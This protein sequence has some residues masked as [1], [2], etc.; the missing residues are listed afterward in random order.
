MGCASSTSPPSSF[1]DQFEIGALIGEGSFGRIYHVERRRPTSL[2]Q[3]EAPGYDN[4]TVAGWA[5]KQLC[6]KVINTASK[7]EASERKRASC[8]A[9][10]AAIW[11]QIGQHVNCVELFHKY[12]QN[13]T[14]YMVME[15]CEG[16]FKQEWTRVQ[17]MLEQDS[18]RMFRELTLGV[19]HLHHVGIVHRDIKIENLLLGGPFGT[20]VKL[21]DFGFATQMPADMLLVG[22]YGTAPYMSP[23]MVMDVGYDC[24]TDVW[25]LGCVIHV[26]LCASFP[27]EVGRI[28][29]RAMKKAIADDLPKL[30][31][32]WADVHD[33]K[34]SFLKHMLDRTQSSRYSAEQVLSLP[35]LS[36]KDSLTQLSLSEVRR[37]RKVAKAGVSDTW[38]RTQAM[39]AARERENPA[40]S[41]GCSKVNGSSIGHLNT[42]STSAESRS[43]RNELLS[44][45]MSL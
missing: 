20:T 13:K 19:A 33:V 31:L 18:T 25:S 2:S 42:S 26:L 6:V 43:G 38:I 41:N 11:R 27:Y 21:A 8:A 24:K 30:D 10:E 14:W 37:M 44:M 5:G 28:D 12:V 7:D 29:L 23:E 35:S 39:Q 22:A 32:N 36:H 16:S 17:H 3:R 1:H 45:T 40:I 15:K 34:L 4:R 9:A